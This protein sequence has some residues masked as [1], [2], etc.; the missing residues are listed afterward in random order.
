MFKNFCSPCLKD[1]H[2]KQRKNLRIFDFFLKKVF[3]LK[4]KTEGWEVQ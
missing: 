2:S 4:K 1:L 3:F